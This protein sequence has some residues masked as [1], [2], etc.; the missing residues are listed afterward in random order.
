[1]MSAVKIRR[2]TKR[3]GVSISL[4]YL[5]SLLEQCL[6]RIETV[7][8]FNRGARQSLRYVSAGQFTGRCNFGSCIANAVYAHC[9]QNN[10]ELNCLTSY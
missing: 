4:T 7:A 8:E 6:E 2:A 10:S 3:T 1:M 9:L 5:L